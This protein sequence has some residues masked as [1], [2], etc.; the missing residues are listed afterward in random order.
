MNDKDGRIRD[1]LRCP[2]G[3]V[4]LVADFDPE[5]NPGYP[6]KGKKDVDAYK[7]DIQEQLD[8][9]QEQLYAEGLSHPATAPSILLILQG[10]DTSGK[11]GVLRHV[12]GMMDPQGVDIHAFKRPTEEELAHDFLW[13]IRNA[14]PKPGVIGI[15]DRS[16]YEDVLVQRVEK[17][18][19]PEEIERRYLAI[20]QFEAQLVANGTRVI[21][22]YLHMSRGE[23]RS[24]LLERL[25]NPEKYY[26]YNPG[27]V[28]TALKFDEYMDAFNIALTKCNT[29][30]A[31]WFVVPANDKWYRNWAIAHL[32]L[33]TM[34]DL[35]LGWPDADFDVA[36]ELERV[37][38]LP[39]E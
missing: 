20:N 23:Q 3:P 5:A 14:V 22:C 17:L 34:A 19:P 12:I 18:A 16:H 10:L 27:D 26:K 25:E 8:Y 6:G 35:G 39:K 28:D 4:D 13:R 9:L 37:Q 32:L 29:D 30:D 31:P 1:L 33:E 11:G 15:F 36:A 21:K 7:D 2:I 24:R 38:A